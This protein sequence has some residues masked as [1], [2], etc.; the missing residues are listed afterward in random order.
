MMDLWKNL[1]SFLKVE[2]E[3]TIADAS[4]A[5]S[6]STISFTVSNTAPVHDQSH[7]DIRFEDVT[8]NIVRGGSTKRVGLGDLS[9]GQSLSHAEN[10]EAQ[11]LIDLR[12][13]AEGNIS[14]A[15]FFRTNN[16][17]ARINLRRGIFDEK[18]YLQLFADCN[19]HTSRDSI[20]SAEHSGV[21]NPSGRISD[22][23]QQVPDLQLR[24]QRILSFYRGRKREIVEK[25][26]QTAHKY[27][28]EVSKELTSLLQIVNTNDERK[29][30]IANKRFATTL[31]S[32]GN[33]IDEATVELQEIVEPPPAK[34]K[35]Y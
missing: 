16:A 31:A 24:L 1:Q 11:E 26:Q 33:I 19:I 9:A 25:H 32:E 12:Y 27:L 34:P 35:F 14:P 23:L 18:A 29:I 28:Q 2:I 21:K 30:L 5:R 15:A 8:L 13:H 17:P 20:T 4:N 10:V 22:A 7:P 6:E 3:I